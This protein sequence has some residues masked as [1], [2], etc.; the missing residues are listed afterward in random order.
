MKTKSLTNC[1]R[2]SPLGGR[3]LRH[4]ISHSSFLHRQEP[5]TPLLTAGLLVFCQQTLLT[6]TTQPAMPP[7][8][9]P[10]SSRPGAT[11]PF[12]SPS[13]QTSAPPTASPPPSY[14]AEPTQYK[15]LSDLTKGKAPPPPP[16][17]QEFTYT[18]Q[19]ERQ[20]YRSDFSQPE[21][22]S[23]GSGSGSGRRMPPPPS[24]YGRG[25]PPPPR[26]TPGECEWIASRN[27]SAPPWTQCVNHPAQVLAQYHRVGPFAT[28]CH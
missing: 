5:R 26:R 16:P 24:N 6:T 23:G 9:I 11:N 4:L 3:L 28:P 2:Q 13:S 10:S 15:S 20:G 21:G 19:P 17:R 12:Y 8:S 1:R 25:T 27:A 7:P 22:G 18:P 14:N